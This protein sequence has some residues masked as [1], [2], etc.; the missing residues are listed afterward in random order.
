MDVLHISSRQPS[1]RKERVV[2]LLGH[3]LQ[4]TQSECMTNDISMHCS[5]GAQLTIRLLYLP[6][7]HGCIMHSLMFRSVNMLHT[8]LQLY[9]VPPRRRLKAAN[10]GVGDRKQSSKARQ[11]AAASHKQELTLALTQSLPDLIHKYQTDAVKVTSAML[12]TIH[13]LPCYIIDRCLRQ[14]AEAVVTI[15]QHIDI[16]WC[17]PGLLRLLYVLQAEPCMQVVTHKTV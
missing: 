12:H 17:H 3:R 7:W 9:L 4:C 8:A 16:L 5:G 11:T 13:T 10:G 6:G 14:H 2:T 1:I 15:S